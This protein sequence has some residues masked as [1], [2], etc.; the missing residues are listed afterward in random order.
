MMENGKNGLKALRQRHRP[1]STR[2]KNGGSF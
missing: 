2:W 1:F